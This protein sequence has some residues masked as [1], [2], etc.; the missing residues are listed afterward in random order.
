MLQK[1]GMQPEA[2]FLIVAC[3]QMLK[4]RPPNDPA[5]RKDFL[6]RLQYLR[7]R[8]EKFRSMGS[9]ILFFH[10]VEENVI[11]RE[12]SAIIGPR[13]PKFG[14]QYRQA[15]TSFRENQT[16]SDV[17]LIANCNEG[18][19]W[20]LVKDLLKPKTVLRKRS[21]RPI[22]TRQAMRLDQLQRTGFESPAAIELEGSSIYC[23]LT[24]L[25]FGNYVTRREGEQLTRLLAGAL[26][27][28]P[29]VTP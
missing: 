25:E 28:N 9:L 16:W 18:E 5:A 2:A 19:K 11:G 10:R 6:L 17:R 4:R 20:N 23:G 12:A 27:L 15:F 8:F 1:R 29:A 24:G 13:L 3:W 22:P 7:D 21:D 14:V 26:I